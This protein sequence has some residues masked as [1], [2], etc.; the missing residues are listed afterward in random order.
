MVATVG[1]RARLVGLY[2]RQ[3]GAGQFD[4]LI[5]FSGIKD[6]LSYLVQ[7]LDKIPASR[8]VA[9]PGRAL[10]SGGRGREFNS[11]HPDH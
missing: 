4:V 11:R 7:K 6:S 5:R 3:A 2:L 1:R 8:G 10:S 9:Q